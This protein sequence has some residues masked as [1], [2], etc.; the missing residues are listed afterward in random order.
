LLRSDVYLSE[1]QKYV[2]HQLEI[3]INSIN[4]AIYSNGLI[5]IRKIDYELAM[6][7]S[8]DNAILERLSNVVMTN[9]KS[10]FIDLGDF[11][12]IH[13]N[14]AKDQ[15]NNAIFGEV[16]TYD[17]SN[18]LIYFHKNIVAC[19]GLDNIIA[20]ETVDAILIADRSRSQDIK[21]IV[22]DLSLNGDERI[23]LHSKY[24]RPWGYYEILS[25]SKLFKVKKILL[26][27]NSSLSLKSHQFRSKHWVV[28]RGVA[29]IHKDG[30]VF[31]IS[32]EEST[33]IPAELKNRLSNQ[34]DENLE[35]IEVQI[36]SYLGEDGIERFNY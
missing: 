2:N 9:L 17:S 25:D 11:N 21:K 8:V 29:T 10:N 23:K 3:A 22:D 32:P 18:Y 30:E 33:F 12:Y 28:I 20:I 15:N 4:N 35:I 34:T 36:G 5:S 7:M 27:P 13:K 31:N 26:K 1:S 14:S 19:L 24:F 16:R 6:D